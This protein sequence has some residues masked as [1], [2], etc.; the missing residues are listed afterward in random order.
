MV[1]D[2]YNFINIQLS[3]TDDDIAGKLK[4]HP[5]IH[6]LL[7]CTGELD[8]NLSIG[9]YYKSTTALKTLHSIAFC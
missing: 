3:M 5:V 8:I 1:V 9:C 7:T 6:D 4:I 2:M